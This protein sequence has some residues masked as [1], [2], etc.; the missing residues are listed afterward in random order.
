MQDGVAHEAAGLVH[1]RFERLDTLEL[2]MRDSRLGDGAVRLKAREIDQVL[3]ECANILRS[4][5]L[6][7]LR[8]DLL[9]RP[10]P[11]S[12]ANPALRSAAAETSERMR[13]EKLIEG[14]RLSRI[15]VA[16]DIVESA[17]EIQD[18][19]SRQF[20]FLAFE[21]E[22]IE[23]LVSHAGALAR[24]ARLE[25]QERDQARC[26]SLDA[27]RRNGFDSREHAFQRAADASVERLVFHSNESL[28]GTSGASLHLR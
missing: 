1:T 14:K 9:D 21:S 23:R 28:F 11:V 22:E 15:E 8:R 3:H 13:V 17:L 16:V 4:R 12:E 26:F 7:H 5:G 25:L 2:E 18:L 6:V 10:F 19:D 20:L 24:S 27:N